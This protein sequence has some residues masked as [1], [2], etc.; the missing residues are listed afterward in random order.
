MFVQK[1]ETFSLENQLLK[2]TLALKLQL[3]LQYV[4]FDIVSLAFKPEN[5]SFM[6][7]FCQDP[8]VR[9]RFSRYL[10]MQSDK[11]IEDFDT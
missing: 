8:G 10:R 2:F 6:Q 7:S 1:Y 9:Q 5:N 11:D 3:D 4:N